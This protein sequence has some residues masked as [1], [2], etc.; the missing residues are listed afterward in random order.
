M[1]SNKTLYI[2]ASKVEMLNKGISPIE[3]TEILDEDLYSLFRK[4]F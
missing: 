4:G 1:N 2:I 3:D